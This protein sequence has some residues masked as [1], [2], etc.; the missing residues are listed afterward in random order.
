MAYPSHP[1][2]AIVGA[3]PYGVSIAA[4]LQAAGVDFRIFGRPMHLWQSQM[5]KGMFLKSDGCASSLSDPTCSYTL[6]RYC[7][8]KGLPYGDR[9]TPVSREVFTQYALSFQRK[10]VPFVE[11]MMVTGVDASRDVFTLRLAN[12]ETASV[13]KVIVA[14]GIA[15]AAH[16]PPVLTR[17]PP[18]LLSH[19]SDHHDLSRFKGRDVI[20]IGGGQS[21]LE[22]AALLSEEGASVRLLVRKPS[23]YWNPMPNMARRSLYHRLRHPVS[24]LG[25]GLELWFDCTAPNLFRYLPQ[26]VRLDRAKA[27]LGPAGAWWLK[28]RVGGMQILPGHFVLKA[29]GR[30][31]RAVLQVSGQDGK[32]INLTTE[33]V[34]AAT[35]YQFAL[36]LLPFLSE[37]LKSQL[38]AE[39]QRPVLSSNFESSVTGLY[40]TGFASANSFGPVMRF[41]H[42]AD[43]TAQRVAHHI[44]AGMRQYGPREYGSPSAFQLARA[45]RCKDF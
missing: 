8:E 45:P 7:G 21:A 30:D 38:R 26:Q 41:L 37:S 19:S 20:V 1:A 6:A 29:A 5:P 4:H 33:H 15:N 36:Q 11:D 43:Y 25:L 22:T 31:G 12:G 34:I 14:T 32:I 23:L 2:V 35:G 18:E 27:V 9:G 28:D 39:D 44:T 40:F 10:L 17:L 13:G 3:G 16:I 42:G 24:N